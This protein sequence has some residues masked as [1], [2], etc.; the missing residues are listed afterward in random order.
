MPVARAQSP[1]VK[2][3]AAS[4]QK[5]PQKSPKT[6]SI[7][8]DVHRFHHG[9]SHAF[10]PMAMDVPRA[11]SSAKKSPPKKSPTPT[12]KSPTPTKKSP[13]PTKKSPTPTKKSVTPTKS[14]ERG[15]GADVRAFHHGDKHAFDQPRQSR[16]RSP[17]PAGARSPS[18]SKSPSPSAKKAAPKEA[19][20]PVRSIADDVH[21]FHH[22]DSK[23]LDFDIAKSAAKPS[24]RHRLMSGVKS[25]SN[26]VLE[27]AGS[28]KN[29]A[30]EKAHSIKHSIK[31]RVS[32][33]RSPSAEKKEKKPS[34]ATRT[35]SPAP[36]GVRTRSSAAKEDSPKRDAAVPAKAT[37]M[38]FHI[39]VV[40]QVCFLILAYIWMACMGIAPTG[41]WM[42]WMENFLAK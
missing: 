39:R 42:G 16:G 1:A 25:K 20:E 40:D 6:S 22:G 24:L 10:D 19:T 9:D 38:S 31:S 2:K 13:T 23:A 7:A 8:E 17:G 29:S 15:I 34:V 11:K 41:G 37:Q 21:R 4:A 18:S 32:R 5:S 35:A 28:I 3:A 30:F 36:M 14:P 12:K 27:K 33:S 26:A